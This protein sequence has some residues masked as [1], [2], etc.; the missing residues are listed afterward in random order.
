MRI[1]DVLTLLA[2]VDPNQGTAKAQQ[3]AAQRLAD[4][5]VYDAVFPAIAFLLVIVLPVATA[6]WVIWKTVTEKAPEPDEK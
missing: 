6:L 5:T 1:H 3:G 4:P 2:T